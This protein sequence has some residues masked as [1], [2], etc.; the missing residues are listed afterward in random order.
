MSSVD[1]NSS[2]IP[3]GTYTLDIYATDRTGNTSNVIRRNIIKYI[4]GVNYNNGIIT[5]HQT[6]S[7]EVPFGRQPNIRQIITEIKSLGLNALRVNMFWESHRYYKNI[8]REQRFLDTINDIANVADEQ[9]VGII[10]NV[11]HQWH[12]SSYFSSGS[13]EGVGF[14]HELVSYLAS[15]GTRTS[16]RITRTINGIDYTKRLAFWF[17][18]DFFRRAQTLDGKDVWNALWDDYY[19]KVVM[20]TKDHKST[21]GYETINEP[22][23]ESEFDADFPY[24]FY[25]GLGNYNAFIVSKIEETIGSKNNKII[26]ID[27]IHSLWNDPNKYTNIKKV[28]DPSKGILRVKGYS[29]AEIR[30]KLFFSVHP[31]QGATQFPAWKANDIA[32]L[33]NSVNLELFLGE[34]NNDKSTDLTP[35]YVVS[36][37]QVFKQLN[38]SW[39]FFP[40]D[41]LYRSSLKDTNYNWKTDSLGRFYKDMLR[42]GI[43]SVYRGV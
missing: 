26:V 33:K 17:W 30:R 12:I 1:I 16:D 42:D 22:N 24:D 6:S 10:Y 27:E 7:Y 21:I 8:G 34:W 28:V 40:Y 37:L 2:S 19:S 25:A 35:E 39:A 11:M 36:A 23:S 3:L 31:Y 38:A 9:N 43:I 5:R 14:P 32:N 41:P 20:L 4:F 18:Y 13:R 15:R 29:D